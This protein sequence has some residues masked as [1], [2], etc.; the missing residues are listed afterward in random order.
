MKYAIPLVL[1]ALVVGCSQEGGFKL[2]KVSGSVTL[3]GQPVAGAGLELSPMPAASPTV[4][5]MLPVVTT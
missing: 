1:I 3:D 4:A 5:P 2:A